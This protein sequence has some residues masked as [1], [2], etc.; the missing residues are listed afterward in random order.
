MSLKTL[1]INGPVPCDKRA[2]ARLVAE[3][4]VGRPVHLLRLDGARDGH[5]NAVQPLEVGQTSSAG[6][7]ASAHC[8]SYTCD[9]VF[10]TIPD[11]LRAVH[12]LERNA[13]VILEADQDPSIRHAWPYDYRIFAMPAPASVFDVFR[14]PHAAADALRQVME[15]TAAFATEIFGLFDANGLDD[16]KGVH[17]GRSEVVDAAGQPHQFEH[18]H[19]GTSHMRHFLRSPIGAE[20]ASR[21]QLQPDYHALVEADVVVIS[22]TRRG[23]SRP[24][25]ACVDRIEKLLS[26]IRHDARRRSLLYWGDLN[27]ELDPVRRK[28]VRRLK[29]L[30]GEP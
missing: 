6:A 4:G 25:R 27:D 30:L 28:L 18:L 13:F 16:S 9:R 15:D 1:L 26:R 10:E 21:I 3:H 22:A 20:I 8:V 17:H 24:V 5:T 19:V 7:W 23:C 12:A 11:A 29:V 14:E 2:I